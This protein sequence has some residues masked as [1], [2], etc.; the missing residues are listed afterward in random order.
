MPEPCILLSFLT[1]VYPSLLT[2]KYFAAAPVV[3][4]TCCYCCSSSTPIY[5]MPN[6]KIRRKNINTLEVPTFLYKKGILL[7]CPNTTSS[8][9]LPPIKIMTSN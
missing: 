6:S 8:N 5:H 3:S 2:I 4:R 7:L 9:E 1:G